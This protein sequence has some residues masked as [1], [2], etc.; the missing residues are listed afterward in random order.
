MQWFAERGNHMGTKANIWA[1]RQVPFIQERLG[2]K[3]MVVLTFLAIADI[4]NDR[5]G[6]LWASQAYIAKHGHVSPRTVREAVGLL[7]GLGLIETESREGA[8]D[9]IWLNYTPTTIFE[10]GREPDEEITAKTIRTRRKPRQEAPGAAAPGAGAPARGADKPKSRT[11]EENHEEAGASSLAR[12]TRL[13]E[14]WEP[15]PNIATVIG[16]SDAEAKDQLERFRDY[17]AAKPGKE[18]RK[19]DW[20]ATWRNWCRNALER[21]SHGRGS[22]AS[23]PSP[24][25]GRDQ[26]DQRV[27]A[28][29]TGA[30]EAVNRRR[31]WGLGN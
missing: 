24:D 29:L 1:W 30:V 25:R 4:A 20:T 18:G 31:R 27:G 21:R 23:S 28:M 17:W 15:D 12:G 3:P 8:A 6:K 9:V 10:G 26:H 11:Q 13:P 2:K 5:T 7:T 16:L 22:P 14:G 19:S